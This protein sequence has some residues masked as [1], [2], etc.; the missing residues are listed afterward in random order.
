M[1]RVFFI[2]L[3]LL[4][5]GPAYAEWVAVTTSKEGD[6]IYIQPNTIRRHGEVV[7]VFVLWDYRVARQIP[8]TRTHF[9]SRQHLQKFNCAKERYRLLAVTWFSGN[10]TEGA[11]LNDDETEVNDW[12]AIPPDSVDRHLMEFVCKR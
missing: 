3:L 12:R 11:R 10:M 4:S 9:L 7:E 2:A 5:V 1:K 6:S 8:N